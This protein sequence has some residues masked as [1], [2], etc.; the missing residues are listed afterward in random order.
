MLVKWKDMTAAQRV[1]AVGLRPK[2]HTS[3][4]PKFAFYIKADG[5]VSRRGGHH[6][7]TKEAYDAEMA[8]FNTPPSDKGGLTKWKPGVT[9]H[10]DRSPH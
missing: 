4:F 7:L 9:F 10:F 5:H 3:D 6:E 2:W 8:K 1:E